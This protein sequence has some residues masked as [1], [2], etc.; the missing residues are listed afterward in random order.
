MFHSMDAHE[1]VDIAMHQSVG[2]ARKA[3]SSK[4]ISTGESR[5]CRMA[6]GTRSRTYHTS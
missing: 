6:P 3:Y 2:G 4:A 5:Q 1:P